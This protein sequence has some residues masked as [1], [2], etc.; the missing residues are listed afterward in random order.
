MDPISLPH[1]SVL[2]M[3]SSLAMNTLDRF[4]SE[5]TAFCGF[6]N[7]FASQRS[8]ALVIWGLL[9]SGVFSNRLMAEI[10]T[11]EYVDAP[12]I[13]RGT[14]TELRFVGAN[15]QSARELLFYQPGLVSQKL[16]AESSEELVVNLRAAD[17]CP[18]GL[19]A[20]RVLSEGGYSELRTICVTPHRVLRQS[21]ATTELTLNTSVVGRF[22][23]DEPS[24]YT[25]AL[26][27]GQSMSLDIEAIRL[28]VDMI[29]P[30]VA[31]RGPSGKIVAQ[32]DDSNLYRQDPIT[33]IIAE[34]TGSYSIEVMDAGRNAGER[35]TYIMHV[36]G[37]P[38]P[39]SVFP[40]GGQP[41]TNIDVTFCG[42]CRGTWT[43]SCLIPEL[44]SSKFASYQLFA[45]RD[46]Q[47]SSTAIPF[48]LSNL[49]NIN[50]SP[51]NDTFANQQPPSVPTFCAINGRIEQP[52]DRDCYWVRGVAGERL[53]IQAFAQRLG[54]AADTL[55][56]IVDSSETPIAQSDDVDSLD[57]RVDIT[58]PRDEVFG[59]IVEEKRGKGGEGFGYRL[60]IV[61]ARATAEVFLPR[62][63]RLGQD[64]QTISIPVANRVLALMAVRKDDASGDAKLRFPDLPDGVTAH[65]LQPHVEQSVIP[66]VFEAS[67]GSKSLG[68]LIPVEVT[69]HSPN[70]TTVG[71]F[72]QVT[73][74]V[75]GP[76]DAIYTEHHADQ[77]AI[78]TREAYPIRIKVVQP[79][80]ALAQDGTLDLVVHIERQ[81]G[82]TGDV[83]LTVPW[84]PAWI[85][86]EPLIVVPAESSQAVIR[87]RAWDKAIKANW[88]LVIE[89]S[90]AKSSRRRTRNSSTASFDTP[91]PT[92]L[93]P[94]SVASELVELRVNSSPATGKFRAAAA[95]QGET[96]T[97]QCNI[98]ASD[99]MQAVTQLV[100]T[101][102]GLPNRVNCE[103]VKIDTLSPDITFSVRVPSDAPTG[104]FRNLACRLTGTLS[105]EAVSY[106]VARD[107]MLTIEKP[108]Q[109]LRDAAGQPLNRI[110]ALRSRSIVP[111]K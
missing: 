63:D 82:F 12:A 18:T 45:E 67:P 87:L 3:R 91:P 8:L 41:G 70:D 11:I 54:S 42:D 44:P 73:D 10:P 85:D 43:T 83:N 96:T 94:Q 14:A 92:A 88:P 40:M 30:A 35:A 55:L 101:L 61:A 50:E 16:T 75:R 69:V 65:Y 48:R 93:F 15:L 57:S 4:E 95:E 13:E 26:H 47:Q 100:A 80:A 79:K 56:T 17:D 109:I 5:M 110:D 52:L 103:P 89:G 53:E 46:G 38:R 31:I 90:A 33:S 7:P 9:L 49:P 105:G 24:N 76:A 66:V 6:R 29:D 104:Q 36:S 27:V 23:D 22:L 107:G 19:H 71:H 2:N 106:V 102:E 51:D 25:I 37:G 28:G 60:E 74:L 84:L 59:I 1:S 21:S 99:D 98:N 32:A 72:H 111:Q 97:I 39:T 34:E 108:G 81:E 20:F 68:R 77:L 78:S 58:V 64:M 86:A 62:R